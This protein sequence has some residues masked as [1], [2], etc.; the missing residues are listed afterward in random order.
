MQTG[1]IFEYAFMLSLLLSDAGSVCELKRT[2]RRHHIE[3]AA[4]LT[5]VKKYDENSFS[6]LCETKKFAG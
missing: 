3:A 4:K 5:E 1:I 6:K 2:K